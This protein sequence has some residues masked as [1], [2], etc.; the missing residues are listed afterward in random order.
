MN[1]R[2]QKG[3]DGRYRFVY[4]DNGY[5]QLNCYAKDLQ[6]VYTIGN[7]QEP[8]AQEL[9]DEICKEE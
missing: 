9:I 2:F 6:D 7:Y 1:I 3:K 4:Y 8:T 5:L